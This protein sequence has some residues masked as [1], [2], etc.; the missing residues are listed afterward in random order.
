MLANNSAPMP[1]S[2][3]WRGFM[4]KLRLLPTAPHGRLGGGGAASRVEKK[5]SIALTMVSAV[6]ARQSPEVISLRSRLL[7]QTELD[8]N[9]RMSGARNTES[10]R[11]SGG[12][13]ATARNSH[14][15]T[16]AAGKLHGK[17]LV[18]RCA[19]SSEFRRR[20]PARRRDQS[21]MASARFSDSAKRAC[22]P[23]RFPFLTK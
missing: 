18:S 2:P 9:R 11:I 20:R 4:V 22:F 15:P 12:S 8:Q 16:Q 13:C 23:R 5:V 14:S 17:A 3:S 7:R 1:E 21:G 6:R 19:R 10:P